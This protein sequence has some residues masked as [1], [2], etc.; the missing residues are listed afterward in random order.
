MTDRRQ[1]LLKD[2]FDLGRRIRI[3]NRFFKS[4]LSEQLGDKDHGPRPDLITLYRRWAEGG[5]GLLVT[6]NVMIDRRFL[7]EPGNVVLEDDR[8]LEAFR[9]WAESTSEHDARL[10][11]QLNHPGKQIPSFLCSEPV[12]PSAVPMGYG[13]GHLFKTPRALSE[14]EIL[15]IVGRFATSSALAREA[16]FGGV[17]IHAAHGYLINQFL[18]PHHNR[19]E[20]DWGGGPSQRRRFLLEVYR[21]MRTAVGD[22][23]PIGIKLNSADFLRGGFSEEA[24]M[25]VVDQ[26]AGEGIDLIEISGGTYESPAMVGHRV[27]ESTRQREAYFLEFAEKV[28][29]RVETPLVVTGGFRS[30]PAM[31]EALNSGATDFVGLGRPLAVEPDLPNRLMGD[32]SGRID[33]PRPTTGFKSVDRMVILDLSWW[34][35]QLR[36]MGRGLDPKA[37]LSAWRSVWTTLSELGVAAF[38]R[39]R[40]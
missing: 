40:A 31:L 22:D 25:T 3:K 27:K 9:G 6:G 34:E 13:L 4:A 16:G 15:E 36:R 12:A 20:D 21:A 37:D 32:P 29:Q 8:H 7:G 19:R 28:R 10:W 14:E 35:L 30:G 23:Y 33:L 18:S 1:I 24:S 11:M 2:S 38:R 26:I 5:A 39:R 17:Q